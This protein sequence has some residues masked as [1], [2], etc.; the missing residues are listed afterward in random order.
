M[1]KL[2]GF[3]PDAERERGINR[4][5][6]NW[7]RGNIVR[8]VK[9]LAGDAGMRV[10]E[11]DPYW[12]SQLCSRC[13]MMGARFSAD[14]G[15]PVFDDASGRKGG[16]VFAC[17][18]CGYTANADHN[19]SVNLH[20]KFYGELATVK[21]VRAG[22]YRVTLPNKTPVEVDSEEIINRLAPRAMRMCSG[23]ATPF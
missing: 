19:A 11:V 6:V 16:S 17:P 4:T 10:V 20:R 2:K 22:V 13:G 8:W 1:E 23:K 7:N 3:I 9:Q 12:T 21:K 15:Q 14:H 18:K 5:L